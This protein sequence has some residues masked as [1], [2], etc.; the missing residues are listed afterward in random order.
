[1]RIRANLRQGKKWSLGS[2]WEGRG[3]VDGRFAG[4]QQALVG[5][6]VTEG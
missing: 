2:S 1:M 3:L 5:T 6:V 4:C